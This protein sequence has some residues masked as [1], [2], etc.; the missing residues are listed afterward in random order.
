VTVITVRVPREIKRRLERRRV[1]VSKTVRTLLEGYVAE[2]ELQDLA[3]RLDA[4]KERLGGR[5][6]GERVARLVRED[7]EARRGIFLMLQH[8]F[9]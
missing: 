1:N 6:D 5:I 7:R 3:A 2:L 9:P 8:S 4:L